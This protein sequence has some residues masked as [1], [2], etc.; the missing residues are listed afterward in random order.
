MS[1]LGI[2]DN[3]VD[4]AKCITDYALIVRKVIPLVLNPITH[5]PLR[6]RIGIHSG[7]VTAGI[8]GFLT[9]HWSLHGDC[10]N[11][12]ARME[13]TSSPGKIHVSEST[14]NLLLKHDIYDLTKRE[15]INVK[16][17][18][19][20]Q[21]W[22]VNGWLKDN[23]A[24]SYKLDKLVEECKVLIQKCKLNRSVIDSVSSV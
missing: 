4:H 11:T 16:G 21:T 23:H 1:G 12:C 13:S 18:G 7:K 5:E 6:I 24:D 15:K 14:A 3:S 19:E 8:T 2:Q 10:V 20:M 17:K 22:W 9:P